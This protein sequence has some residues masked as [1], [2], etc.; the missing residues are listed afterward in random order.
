MS[1]LRRRPGPVPPD[2]YAEAGRRYV[3]WLKATFEWTAENREGARFLPL[4]L[5]ASY[6]AAH[7]V[8]AL[9][10]SQ[11]DSPYFRQPEDVDE[12][13]TKALCNRMRW[14]MT[15]IVGRETT[16][17]HAVITAAMEESAVCFG[18]DEAER[19]TARSFAA[20]LFDT[21]TPETIAQ[22][23]FREMQSGYAVAPG[24]SGVICAF[25]TRPV[26]RPSRDYVDDSIDL[27]TTNAEFTIPCLHHGIE[28]G[29]EI[30][31]E[32]E[33]LGWPQVAAYLTD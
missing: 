7:A 15:F 28:A 14:A 1:V 6:A 18:R 2:R 23:T 24:E 8:T 29:D 4:H 16:T 32:I 19:K 31:D 3:A 30:L 13:T 12:P 33:K 21:R 22:W 17:D 27:L 5:A 11:P 9:L 10:H 20:Q 26:A 25:V